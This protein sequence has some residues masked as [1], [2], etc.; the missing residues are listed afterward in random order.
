MRRESDIPCVPVS[1]VGSSLAALRRE[2]KISLAPGAA[3]HDFLQH[4]IQFADLLLRHHLLRQLRKFGPVIDDIAIGPPDFKNRVG[5]VEFSA[6]GKGGITVGH[7]HQGKRAG[8]QNHGRPGFELTLNAHKM[9]RLDDGGPADID[10]QPD[11]HRVVG[12]GDSRC[13]RDAP[14]VF[15]RIVSGRPAADGDR[16]IHHHAGGRISVQKGGQIDERLERRSRLPFRIGGAVELA[17]FII[18]PAD[19]GFH[20]P[21]RRHGHRGHLR[22]P[23]AR[24][25]RIDNLVDNSLGCRLQLYVNRGLDFDDEIAGQMLLFK[26]RQRFAIGPIHEPVRTVQVSLRDD[27]RRLAPCLQKLTLGNEAR[28]QHAVEHDIGPGLCCFEIL[29]RCIFCGRLEKA[30]QHGGFRKRHIAHRFA[31]IELRRRFHPVIAATQIGAVEIEL[32]DFLLRKAR[33]DPQREESLVNLAL[34]R[35]LRTEE[36]I[37]CNLL[38]DG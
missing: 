6:R 4:G 29:V 8:S 36:K 18:A 25:F 17:V 33:L 26:N 31:E 9:G 1:L 2:T 10:H 19:D 11:G 27:R 5:R 32:Q 38:R 24:P 23:V 14:A 28:I 12:L 15:P 7:I 13:Q 20:S 3:F 16:R 22:K 34:D 37:F 30:S 21:F 35:A